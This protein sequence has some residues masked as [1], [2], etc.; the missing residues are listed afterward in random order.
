[1]TVRGDLWDVG[2]A[3]PPDYSALVPKGRRVYSQVFLNSCQGL[4]A[5]RC[6]LMIAG[7]YCLSLFG[8]AS[9]GFC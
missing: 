7:Q 2:L 9:S 6:C 1:M 4:W 8:F 5:I 3:C